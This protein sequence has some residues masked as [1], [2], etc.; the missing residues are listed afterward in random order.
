[1]QLTK[2][3]IVKIAQEIVDDNVESGKPLAECTI[4]KIKG[5]DLNPEQVK[6]I[7]EN[8]NILS[9]LKR[10]E[11]ASPDEKDVATDFEVLDPNKMAKLH[12]KK[13]SESIKTS[14]YIDYGDYFGTPPGVD[15]SLEKTASELK[16]KT[17]EP[18]LQEYPA[19]RKNKVLSNIK[20]AIEKLDQSK[21]N[22]LFD[23][24]K[25]ASELL[26]QCKGIYFNTEE[27]MRNVSIAFQKQAEPHISLLL[28]GMNKKASD[29][30]HPREEFYDNEVPGFNLFDRMVKLSEERQRLSKA[31]DFLFNMRESLARTWGII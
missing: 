16:Y 12:L 29:F 18:I 10:Y 30:T 11:D 31:R 5:L 2:P 3:E 26:D 23:Y 22:A 6:R 8:T 17:E 9:F 24:H 25:V 7:A 14:S 27:L 13:A 21:S 20:I 15:Y 19:A 28:K 1:M 4:I